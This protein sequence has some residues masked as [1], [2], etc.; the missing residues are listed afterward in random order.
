MHKVATL[1]IVQCTITSMDK[2]TWR[3]MLACFK[4]ILRWMYSSTGAVG[5]NARI[6]LLVI[7]NER[8]TGL[9]K[10][11]NYLNDII[12][13][14]CNL[15]HYWQFPLFIQRRHQLWSEPSLKTGWRFQP[16]IDSEVHLTIFFITTGQL[17]K[18]NFF[19]MNPR[20]RNGNGSGFKVFTWETSCEP[21]SN[22]FMLVAKLIK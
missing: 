8:E 3:R 5:I 19:R 12:E 14:F 7:R 18:K 15:S 17:K 21:L 2:R 13:Y 16:Y 1:C 10:E 6:S 4:L 11:R 22:F 9:L 20:S